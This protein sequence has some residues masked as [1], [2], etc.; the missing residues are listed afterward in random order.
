MCII[1]QFGDRNESHIRNHHWIDR[2]I[3]HGVREH[4]NYVSTWNSIARTKIHGQVV[5]SYWI[6]F[7]ICP[8]GINTYH[9]FYSIRL[10]H[11]VGQRLPCADCRCQWFLAAGKMLFKFRDD[12]T[13]LTEHPYSYNVGAS[14]TSHW[15]HRVDPPENSIIQFSVCLC[16]C[17]FVLSLEPTPHHFPYVAFCSFLL[18]YFAFLWHILMRQRRQTATSEHERN[19][20]GDKFSKQNTTCAVVHREPWRVKWLQTLCSYSFANTQ[21]LYE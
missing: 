5:E 9:T 11:C 14:L 20:N 10:A 4:I 21:N 8:N 16:V 3:E 2:C 19:I 12:T 6:N 1:Y 7:P 17:V 18:I 15:V 13:A